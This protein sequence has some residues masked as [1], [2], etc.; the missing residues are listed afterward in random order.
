LIFF[1][2]RELP[3]RLG[4][5]IG[6]SLILLGMLL[7]MP[8]LVGIL[9]RLVQPVCRW[10]FG[11]ETR[12]AADN[13][14]RSPGRT[15]VV[16][17]A[18]AAGVTL[19]IVIAGVRKSQEVPINEWL[20]EVIRADAYLFRG[21]MVSANSSM[22][23]MEGKIRDDLRAL[24]GVER[25][26]GLRFYRPEYRGT[27][28]LLVGID[29]AD[30][31]QAIRARVP[32]G[33]PT[34]DL[35]AKL[36]DGN[37]TIVSENFAYK[38][39]VKVGDVV[40]VP[41]P[42]GMIDLTVIGIGRDY[43]WAQGTIFVDRTKYGDLF[44]DH[45]VDAYHVFFRPEADHA[46]TYKTVQQFADGEQL[47]VQN[48]ESV[49]TYLAGVLDRIFLIAYLLQIIVAIVSL[50]GV[51]MALMISVLQRRREL[52]LL[53]S[54]GA[55]RP[56]VMKSVLAEATLMGMLG[57]ILGFAIGLPIEWFL[58]R[59]FFIEETGLVYEMLVPWK[60]GLGIGAISIAT[61]TIAGLLP[62]VH[63]IRMRITDAIAYE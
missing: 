56:Q 48:R 54:V 23:P 47:L 27:F 42:R 32:D 5:L 35:M 7:A 30:Y 13:L 22:T 4:S 29:A 20:S 3:S 38:W 41:G 34:L 49:Q 37:T 10:L 33:L 59:V 63:A 2:R 28:I 18:L 36:P 51:V 6:M 40:T 12:L 43:S 8:I 39:N 17:G 15:G 16:I 60:Q 24:P 9:A 57:T 52:G 58:L 61:A 45:V 46:A 11:V 55:T 44:D 53:R 19:M 50:L 25:V 62:A 1:Y 21:N 14:I 26:V 31:Q